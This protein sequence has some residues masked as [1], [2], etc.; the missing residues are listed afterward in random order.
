MAGFFAGIAHTPI[1]T[2]LMVSELTGNYNLLV[3][4]MWVCAITFILCRNYT[5]YEK[6]V[7]SRFDSPVHR[8]EY[9]MSILDEIKVKDIM[10]KNPETIPENMIFKEILEYIPKTK[11][12]IFP[13]VNSKG[14]LEGIISFHNIRDIVFEEGLENL[15]VAKDLVDEKTE[16]IFP[17]SN[18]T[19]AVEKF[20]MSE[21]DMLPVVDKNNPKK[22]LGIITRKDI[23]KAYDQHIKEHKKLIEE[24]KKKEFV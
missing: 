1:S 14:E 24:K 5:I 11:Y 2:L 13:V 4:T 7:F 8:K 22:L 17:D 20:G 21:A 10:V 6:Q 18:L 16:K 23:M 9:L 19:E 15:I 12:T 3:P